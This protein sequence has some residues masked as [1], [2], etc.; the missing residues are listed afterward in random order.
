MTT[1]L[2][3]SWMSA[4]EQAELDQMTLD[5]LAGAAS[6]GLE[7]VHTILL[8]ALERARYLGV[9]LTAVLATINDN[10][11]VDQAYEYATACEGAIV[12]KLRQDRTDH[13]PTGA[14]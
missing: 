3:F 9:V 4:D 12:R 2:T 13:A 5:E 1:E 8:T 14:A 10:P 6:A 11:I 7:G